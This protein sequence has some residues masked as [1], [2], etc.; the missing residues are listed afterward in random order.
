[1]RPLSSNTSVSSRWATRPRSAVTVPRRFKGVIHATIKRTSSSAQAR[2]DSGTSRGCSAVHCCALPVRPC[3][4]WTA[5][6]GRRFSRRWWFPW[7]RLSRRRV[8][9]W[10]WRISW[11]RVSQRM[12]R[13]LRERPQWFRLRP[14]Q[15]M[16]PRLARRALRLGGVGC[17]ESGQWQVGRRQH[18]EPGRDRGVA[19]GGVQCG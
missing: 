12:A 3:P 10:I 6:R 7:R 15:P 14:R 17:L 8:S 18:A 1:M 9:R 2:K 11:Q 4:C 16:V 5:W 19:D 13:W